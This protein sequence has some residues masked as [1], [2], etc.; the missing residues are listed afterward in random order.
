MGS[1]LADTDI[2]RAPP[3]QQV[4]AVAK[5]P[6]IV[7]ESGVPRF[8]HRGFGSA[9]P[10]QIAELP[11]D[12]LRSQ[13]Y[14][15]HPDA[16]DRI[17]AQSG[18]PL[19]IGLPQR[20]M[21]S[22]WKS[23]GLKTMFAENA[24]SYVSARDYGARHSG[25]LIQAAGVPNVAMSPASFA[26][27]NGATALT[28]QTIDPAVNEVPIA[29]GYLPPGRYVTGA[30]L[31]AYMQDDLVNRRDA[32]KTA[33]VTASNA[34]QEINAVRSAIYDRMGPPAVTQPWYARRR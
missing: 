29:R 13:L 16:P 4:A 18:Q 15:G 19:P 22:R 9:T 26:T 8:H 1:V 34:M 5:C 6:S 23:G 27:S 17:A 14:P 2:T 25:V 3:G 10:P 31:N 7:E 28:M 12:A 21:F 33:S 20:M 24:R 11:L 32:A 30:D